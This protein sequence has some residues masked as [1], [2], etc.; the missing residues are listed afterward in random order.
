MTEAYFQ[1][2]LMDD[3]GTHAIKK[4]PLFYVTSIRSEEEK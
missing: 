3:R 4:G 1:C 2:E